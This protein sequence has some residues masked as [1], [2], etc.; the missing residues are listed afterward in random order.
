MS[1]S[2]EDLTSEDTESIEAPH[3][4]PQRLRRTYS[5][6]IDVLAVLP[7]IVIL[8]INIAVGGSLFFRGAYLIIASLMILLR[9]MVRLGY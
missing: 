3:I 8:L 2:Y 7:F 5:W 4:Q 1:D 6:K 9:V